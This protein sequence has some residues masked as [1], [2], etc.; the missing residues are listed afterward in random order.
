M[1]PRVWIAVLAAAGLCALSAA[2][3]NAINGLNEFE[4]IDCVGACSD[5]APFPDVVEDHKEAGKDAA[6]AATEEAAA[7]DTGPPDVVEHDAPATVKRR[8]AQWRMPNFPIDG[9]AGL[10]NPASYQLFADASVVH[11]NVT[12][13]RWERDPV[14]VP[15]TYDEA[16]LYCKGLTLENKTWE[17]PTRIELVSLLDPT[18]NPSIDQGAFPNEQGAEYWT[19]SPVARAIEPQQWT[20]N[21]ATG[22]VQGAKASTT[23]RV[24]CVQP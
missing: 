24:R 15:K 12:Q 13:M 11:D 2:A 20:V 17:V 23:K 21:F 14:A 4:K 16:V 22:T 10:P 18:S 19:S 6:D 7:P 1:R 5:A 3:C 9:D 8:W